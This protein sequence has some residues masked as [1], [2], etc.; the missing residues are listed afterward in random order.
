MSYVP[1]SL[2]TMSVSKETVDKIQ[3]F[4]QRRQKAEAAYE[5]RPLS[6]E[7]L[8]TYNRRLDETLKLLQGRLKRQEDELNKVCLQKEKQSTGI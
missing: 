2:A 5:Q 4:S 1:I 8:H 3:R 7:A 6:H